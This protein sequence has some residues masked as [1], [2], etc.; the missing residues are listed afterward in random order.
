MVSVICQFIYCQIYQLTIK[1]KLT[2]FCIKK[3]FAVAEAGEISYFE[4]LNDLK[5]IFEYIN[6]NHLNF[7]FLFYHVIAILH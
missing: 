2:N 7:I 5:L 1:K 4:L 3:S 6:I